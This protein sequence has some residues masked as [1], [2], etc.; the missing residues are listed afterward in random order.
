MA[1]IRKVRVPKALTRRE[2]ARYEKRG[3][4]VQTGDDLTQLLIDN[5]DVPGRVLI[6]ASGGPRVDARGYIEQTA[7][8][9]FAALR[10]GYARFMMGFDAPLAH[11]VRGK[12]CSERERKKFL[13][14]AAA[15]LG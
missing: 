13:R 1:H 15:A 5:C 4:L 14:I 6:V 8:V 10:D 11:G 3:Y 12:P 7:Y 2:Q 9:K